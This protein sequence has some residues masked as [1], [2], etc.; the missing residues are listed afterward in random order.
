VRV[1]SERYAI[2][3]REVDVLAGDTTVVR[4]ELR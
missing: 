4:I 2:A 1:H 3:D